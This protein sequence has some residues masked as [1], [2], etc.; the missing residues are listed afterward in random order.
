M[1]KSTEDVAHAQI[2]EDSARGLRR[3]TEDGF[4]RAPKPVMA[5]LDPAI[6]AFAPGIDCRRLDAR[7]K[8]AHDAHYAEIDSG[9]L[10]N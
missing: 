2:R 8:S 9:S 4:V 10:R 5:G 3:G 6:H 1:S 7:I